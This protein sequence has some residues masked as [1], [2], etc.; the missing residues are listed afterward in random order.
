MKSKRI[1]PPYWLYSQG[2]PS[3]NRAKR[4]Y[5]DSDSGIS[6]YFDIGQSEE[7]AWKPTHL[8]ALVIWNCCHLNL[9]VKN[10][11]L[12]GISQLS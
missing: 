12:V 6:K 11:E 3:T 8:F 7:F 10:R 2:Y 9:V 4:L 5:K 1:N